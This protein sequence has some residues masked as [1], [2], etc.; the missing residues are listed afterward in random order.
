MFRDLAKVV[1]DLWDRRCFVGRCKGCSSLNLRRLAPLLFRT[2]N[3]P[4]YSCFV[5][6][7]EKSFSKVEG[8]RIAV[9][10]SYKG[11][12][13]IYFASFCDEWGRRTNACWKWHL[14]RFKQ[15]NRLAIE[16]F[17]CLKMFV[18]GFRPFRRLILIFRLTFASSKGF[19]DHPASL[20]FFKTKNLTPARTFFMQWF[21]LYSS[22]AS[23]YFS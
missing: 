13:I 8:R 14:N 4:H 2:A 11:W 17:S 10:H 12:K 3:S 21:V 22:H 1:K 16:T 5:G 19:W 15:A 9:I 18:W 23:S 20:C 6:K 7:P